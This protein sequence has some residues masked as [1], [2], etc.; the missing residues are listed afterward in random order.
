MLKAKVTT[1][2]NS[3]GIVLSKEVLSKLHAGKGDE[4]FLI[5]TPN[6][7]EIVAYD[8][9]FE[10]Q[11]KAAEKIRKKRKNLMRLLAKS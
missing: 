11:M 3:A 1:V 6:G 2:G 4:V 10:K 8:P 5:E 7:Y 9:E